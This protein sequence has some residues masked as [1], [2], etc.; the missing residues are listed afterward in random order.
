MVNRRKTLAALA[1]GTASALGAPGAPQP[2]PSALDSAST[3]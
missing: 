2:M 3:L 1:A